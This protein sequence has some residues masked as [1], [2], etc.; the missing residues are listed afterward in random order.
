MTGAFPA[1]RNILIYL[2]CVVLALVLGYLL[3]TPLNF[4][5]LAFVSLVVF[6][7]GF[8][9]ALAWH[10]NVLIWTWNSSF[11][12]FFLP[13]QPSLQVFMVAISLGFSLLTRTLRRSGRFISAPS[14]TWPLV[15]LALVIIGTALATGGIGGRAL[16]A[17]TWGGKRYLGLIGAIL[18]YFA[19][20][21][22]SLSGPN[23]KLHVTGY[24]IFAVTSLF[25]DLA[26]AIGPVAYFLFAFFSTDSA[27]LQ[28]QTESG[29][30][31]LSGVGFA[32]QAVIYALMLKFTVRGLFDLERPWR[33]VGLLVCVGGSLLGGYRS[34]V[35]V[36]G[37]GFI[38]QFWYE[39]LMRTKFLPIVLLTGLVVGSFGIAFVDKLPLSVQRS[40]S[41][42]PLAVDSQA[43]HDASSTLDWRIQIWR[44]VIKEVPDHLILGKG[45]AY[46]GADYQLTQEAVR[47][48]IY[49][50]Y[51]DTLIS[52]NYH[53]GILT[54][55]VPFGLFGTFAF[56]W[57]CWAAF[58]ALKSNYRYGD[59]A[60]KAVNT[61]LL[62]FFATR[63]AFYLVFYGQF[64]LD[65]M[66]FTGVVG[67]SLALNGGI[68]T[69]ENSS[70]PTGQVVAT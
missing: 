27:S 65:L 30:W 35:I 53:N 40:I 12:V 43:K 52:G 59:P 21:A 16:G 39:G 55:L 22:K 49:Q 68:R 61:F 44:I 24:F 70:T 38:F 45:Y 41:F 8:P 64:D 34:V 69:P 48:G 63:L 37:L 62:S 2:S 56:F 46:S 28:A 57:F 9:L 11:I 54:L 32:F 60:L 4:T 51:E 26:Y 17:G 10:H 20:T 19:L 58:K 50:A 15:I 3:A 42:L 33:L 47:R 67:L 5:S 66:V 6:V 36:I 31:R 13:G 29:L 1:H 23:P 18:G 7:L 25:S 14:V